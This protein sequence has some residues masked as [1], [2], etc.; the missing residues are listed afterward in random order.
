MEESCLGSWEG[1]G[2]H[3][4]HQALALGRT[5]LSPPHSCTAR[6]G[7]LSQMLAMSSMTG[8]RALLWGHRGGEPPGGTTGT[9]KHILETLE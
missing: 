8:A 1:W 4:K 9:S 5:S 7:C 2:R 6:E 3:H